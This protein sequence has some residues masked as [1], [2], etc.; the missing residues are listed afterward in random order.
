MCTP[1]KNGE[2]PSIKRKTGL[3][4]LKTKKA[5]R[6]S[7]FFVRMRRFELP[8]PNGHHPLKVAC[9]PISPHARLG[10]AKVENQA[11]GSKASLRFSLLFLLVSQ[12]PSFQQTEVY[13]TVKLQ[14]SS[15]LPRLVQ[16]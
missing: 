14:W 15:D 13:C 2:A 6:K 8:H 16:A 7:P 3:G 11:L 12:K 4:D 5:T 9:L 10:I 1:M